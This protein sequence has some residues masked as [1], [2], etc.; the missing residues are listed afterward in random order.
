MAEIINYVNVLGTSYEVVRKNYDE[1]DDFKRLGIN[2]YCDWA[3]KKV[4]FCNMDTYEGYEHETDETKRCEERLTLR[5][6]IVHAFCNE[7]GLMSNAHTSSGSVFMDEEVVDFF[8]IQGPKIYKAWCELS[9][10]P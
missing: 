5:H 6:E 4:V 3:G 1:D 2:G 8:A 9:I 10:L 7:S